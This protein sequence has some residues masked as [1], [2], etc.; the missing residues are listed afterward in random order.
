MPGLAFSSGTL[1]LSFHAEVGTDDGT[2][3]LT[4]IMT[5]PR[6]VFSNDAKVVSVDR[7]YRLEEMQQLHVKNDIG[8]I[9]HTV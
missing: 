5:V 2:T 1:S 3:P 6:Q 8:L 4:G 7:R 9:Q